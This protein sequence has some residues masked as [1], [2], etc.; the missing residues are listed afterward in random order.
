M[1]GK[2]NK[3]EIE[4]W[5]LE[6][7]GATIDD[8]PRGDVE[9]GEEPDFVVVGSSSRTGIEL[10]RL[11]QPAPEDEQPLQETE[12]LRWRICE[13]AQTH[14]ESEGGAPH[15]VYVGFSHFRRIAKP[16][17][18]PLTDAVVRIVRSLN[19][20]P[21]TSGEIE[22]DWENRDL[23]PDEIVRVRAWR[24][25]R[26]VRCIWQPASA[27]FVST[28]PTELVKS[29]VSA[30]EKLLPAY[31]RRAPLHWLVLVAEGFGISS[32]FEFPEADAFGH[33]QTAFHRVYYFD[34]FSRRAVR[35]TI[36]HDAS[37][38]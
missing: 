25:E 30:K 2:P 8:F 26:D 31:R 24:P 13:A 16:R 3:K 11:F 20:P 4:F 9:P 18:K 22:Y 27:G 14:F 17:V 12:S 5:Q 7:F 6:R 33:L 15:Q 29:V 34:S 21:G 19:I 10:V 1:V 32:T 37:V 38:A 28:P 35:L 23:F 36:D